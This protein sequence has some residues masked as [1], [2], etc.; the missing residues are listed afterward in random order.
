MCHRVG[1]GV[2]GGLRGLLTRAYSH[3]MLDARAGT[4]EPDSPGVMRVCNMQKASGRCGMPVA[5]TLGR[6]ALPDIPHY[7]CADVATS[8]R[9]PTHGIIRIFDG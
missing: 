4:L 7:T 1:G 5:R 6:V 2:G 9:L 8:Q 3:V